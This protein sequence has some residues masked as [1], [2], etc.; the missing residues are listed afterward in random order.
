MKPDEVR[1]LREALDM[2]QAQFAA[3]VGVSMNTVWR[4]ENGW[5]IDRAW[6]QVIRLKTVTAAAQAQ[7]A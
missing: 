2:T 5:P 3:L 1:S 4:W 6:A 7:P